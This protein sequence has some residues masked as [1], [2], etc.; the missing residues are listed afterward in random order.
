MYL[1]GEKETFLEDKKDC[2]KKKAKKN[3]AE[4]EKHFFDC[5]FT[6]CPKKYYILFDSVSINSIY[7]TSDNSH[8]MSLHSSPAERGIKQDVKGIIEDIYQSGLTKHLYINSELVRRGF[9][10]LRMSSLRNFISSI[11][12]KKYGQNISMLNELKS[13]LLR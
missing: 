9:Q 13:W 10:E 1:S 11:S 6:G 5:K 8:D 2:L 7:Y 3:T 4:G 12:K